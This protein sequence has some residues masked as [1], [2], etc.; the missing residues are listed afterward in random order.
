[1]ARSGLSDWIVP[2]VIVPALLLLFLLVVVVW[3]G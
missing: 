1:M 3:R 2:A